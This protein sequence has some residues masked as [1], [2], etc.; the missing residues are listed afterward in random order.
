MT[1][2]EP[3]STPDPPAH[4]T[5]E[6]LVYRPLEL[7]PVLAKSLEA[8]VEHGYHGTTV[9][10]IAAR[11]KQTIPTIYYYYENKQALL[12]ALLHESIDDLLAR[13]KEAEAS[14]SDD[15]AERL[16][17]LILCMSTFV[18]HR[19][20]LAQ[21]DQEVRSLETRNRASYIAKRDALEA[22][23]VS[24]IVDGKEAG[25][26]TVDDPR[27]ASRA[28]ITMCRGIAAW[29]KPKGELAPE[30][31]AKVYV[32]FGLGLVGVCNPPT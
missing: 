26:F 29:Y 27:T 4:V 18:A 3:M 6:W 14:V 9:R 5:G 12:V 28:L 19:R 20:Q 31:L 11:L 32:R 21:L 13:C 7:P 8:F 22:M 17:A 16:S 15:P 1:D 10:N 2:E 23:L 24:C 30:S 25:I